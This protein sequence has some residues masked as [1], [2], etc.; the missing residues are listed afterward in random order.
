MPDVAPVT[1]TTLPSIRVAV[2]AAAVADDDNDDEDES[3]EEAMVE[4]EVW[5]ALLLRCQLV[6]GA[7]SRGVSHADTA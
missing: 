5:S 7:N 1:M 3:R 2:A 4:L 6:C